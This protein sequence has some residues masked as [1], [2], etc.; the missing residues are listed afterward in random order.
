MLFFC[1]V[2]QIFEQITLKKIGITVVGLYPITLY[3][4][5]LHY[6]TKHAACSMVIGTNLDIRI[7]CR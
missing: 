1:D 2:S 5:Y 7:L 6:Y 3:K 4:L